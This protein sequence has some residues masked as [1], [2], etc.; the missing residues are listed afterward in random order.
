MLK[1]S[2]IKRRYIYKINR[3]ICLIQC[4]SNIKTIKHNQKVEEYKYI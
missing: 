2:L 1:N 4:E 3:L